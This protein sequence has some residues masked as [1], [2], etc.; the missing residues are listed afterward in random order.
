MSI[1]TYVRRWLKWPIANLLLSSLA[2][3]N[4][5]PW[6]RRCSEKIEWKMCEIVSSF[7]TAMFKFM[8]RLTKRGSSLLFEPPGGGKHPTDWTSTTFFQPNYAGDLS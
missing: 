2:A 5:K 4:L 8:K 7:G 6:K 3:S 1:V